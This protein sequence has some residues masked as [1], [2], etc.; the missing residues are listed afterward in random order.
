MVIFFILLK[1]TKRAV[2]R[3]VLEH[4]TG[5]FTFYQFEPKHETT[6]WN[7]GFYIKNHKNVPK[8]IN[9]ISTS[10]V[11]AVFRIEPISHKNSNL[12]QLTDS[13]IGMSLIGKSW[14]THPDIFRNFSF[15]GCDT[16]GF[17]ENSSSIFS[18]FQF[19]GHELDRF[20]ENKSIMIMVQY[21]YV[22][23]WSLFMQVLHGFHDNILLW[24]TTRWITG[25]S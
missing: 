13:T 3:S 21:G 9:C 25:R 20:L 5:P 12:F 7:G 8:L 17:L 16:D 19:P 14:K 10:F 18:K 1:W 23:F 15:L 4:Q 6:A 11:F 24:V 22:T 2:I